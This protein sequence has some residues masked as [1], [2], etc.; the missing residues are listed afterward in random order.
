M[1]A[2][3]RTQRFDSKRDEVLR[4]SGRVFARLGFRAATL[5]DIGAELGTTAAALYYYA[6]SKDQLFGDCRQIGLDAIDAALEEGRTTGADGY[7]RLAIF[8][9]R[10]AELIVSDFGRCLALAN[11]SDIPAGL[12]EISRAR[13]GSVRRDVQGLIRSGV[14]DGSVRP[15]HDLLMANMLFG[16]FNHLPRWWAPDGPQSLEA[17]ARAY[18]ETLASHPSPPAPKAHQAHNRAPPRRHA[19][20]GS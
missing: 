19:G 13:Q 11:P 9:R 6:K 7:S 15:C 20:D 17:V 4:A 5:A 1:R 8:F 14:A 10:Y 2:A 18:V 12:R 3:T 16:A